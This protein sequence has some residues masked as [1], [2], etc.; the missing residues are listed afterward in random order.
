[1]EKLINQTELARRLGISKS[2]LSKWIN[3]YNVS[4]KQT[5]GKQ[6]L[7]GET[8]VNMLKQLQTAKHEEKPATAEQVETLKKQ[9]METRNENEALKEQVKAKDQRLDQ[10]TQQVTDQQEQL[11]KQSAALIDQTKTISD[12]GAKFA[13]LADQSQKLN[14]LDKPKEQ[15]KKPVETETPEQ[16]T[17]PKK[18]P[19]WSKFF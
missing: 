16:P 10:L 4:P 5:N 14:L 9:L 3:K 7:Y 6:K 2:T 18:K 8:A 17:T 13:K 1:M 15:E 12:F 11:K 19:F